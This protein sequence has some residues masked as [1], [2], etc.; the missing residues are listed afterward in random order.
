MRISTYLS[1][2]T[3][4]LPLTT[5]LPTPHTA[6]STHLAYDGDRTLE[7][8][9]R[10]A[11]S[12]WKLRLLARDYQ[13]ET[14]ACAFAELFFGEDNLLGTDPTYEEWR[15]RHWHVLPRKR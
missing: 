2:L 14:M 12:K 15:T 3:L 5:A 13:G 11:G 7:R 6:L 8:L 10:K 9:V 4:T 1:L